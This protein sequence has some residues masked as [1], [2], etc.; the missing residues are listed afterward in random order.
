MERNFVSAISFYFMYPICPDGGIGRH[1]GLKQF[2]CAGGNAGCIASQIRGNL[3]LYR[4]GNPEPSPGLAGEGV[5][6]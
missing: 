3:L 6:T 1:A 2:E 4:N 5:E